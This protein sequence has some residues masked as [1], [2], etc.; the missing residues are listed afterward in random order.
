MRESFT[1]IRRRPVGR[2]DAVQQQV[3]RC[4]SRG[5]VDQL[6]A[7]REAVAQ[8]VALGGRQLGGVAGGVLVRGKQE[9]GCAGARVNDS[10]VGCRLHAVDH[11]LDER[12]VA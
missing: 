12:A 1:S 2:A 10:V 4:E 5:A 9:A 3:H 8:M 11:R 7:V 6:V